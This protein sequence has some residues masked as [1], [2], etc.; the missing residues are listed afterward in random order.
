M[1]R[2]RS[3]GYGLLGGNTF[4]VPSTLLGGWRNPKGFTPTTAGASG[5]NSNLLA[6]IDSRQANLQYFR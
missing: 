1:E 3:K 2:Y 5:G 6:V 4:G